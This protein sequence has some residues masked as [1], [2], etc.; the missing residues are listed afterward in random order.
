MRAIVIRRVNEKEGRGREVRE[1]RGRGSHGTDMID[2]PRRRAQGWVSGQQHRGF[3]CCRLAVAQVVAVWQRGRP[4]VTVFEGLVCGA[5]GTRRARALR[6]VGFVRKRRQPPS[7]P[8]SGWLLLL[9]SRWLLGALFAFACDA[10]GYVTMYYV[11]TSP[12]HLLRI[13][14]SQ[15]RCASS[16]LKRPPRSG[17]RHRR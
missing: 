8:A 14:A 12:F 16:D 10:R 5:Q 17:R 7:S 6:R 11:L 13:A 3:R 15:R 9:E 1:G 2:T 4:G